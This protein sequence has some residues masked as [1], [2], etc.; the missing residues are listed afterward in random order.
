MKFIAAA[1]VT[2]DVGRQAGMLC[3]LTVGSH[4][5]A[6]TEVKHKLGNS[7]KMGLIK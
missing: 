2:L 6:R 5:P 4:V 7:Y 3:P 1:D